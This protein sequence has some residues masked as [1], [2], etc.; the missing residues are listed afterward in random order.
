MR[1]RLLP[2][3]ETQGLFFSIISQLLLVLCF[4]REILAWNILIGMFLFA[5]GQQ[6]VSFARVPLF[7]ETQSSKQRKPMKWKNRRHT[8]HYLLYRRL[9]QRKHRTL[10]ALI[11]S[12]RVPFIERH[13][14]R[15]KFDRAFYAEEVL[16]DQE[17]E[18]S[19]S[20]TDYLTGVDLDQFCRTMDPIRQYRL[21]KEFQASFVLNT[22][23]NSGDLR[24]CSGRKKWKLLMNDADQWVRFTTLIASA[25]G[26]QVRMDCDST[27][28]EL[29]CLELA[30]FTRKRSVYFSNRLNDLPIVIDSGATFS[31]T[32]NRSDFIGELRAAPVSELNGLSSTTAVEGVGTVEWTIRDLFGVTR[33]IRTQAC[34]VPKASIRLFSPQAY[35]QDQNAGQYLMTPKRSVLTLADGSELEFPYNPGSNLPLMLPSVNQAVAGLTF[36]DS[37]YLTRPTLLSSFLS[38][39]DETNQNLTASQKELLV[40]HWKLGH[41]GFQWVQHLAST[42]R[43]P[44]DGIDYPILH[45]KHPRVS[46]CPAPLCTACQLAKQNRRGAGTS[47]EI[48]KS[49]KLHLLRRDEDLL[50]GRKVSIDQYISSVPGRLPNTKGKELKKDR[51][52]GGTLFVDHSSAYV[53]LQ[54][55]VSLRVGETLRAKHSFEK[56]AASHGVK[57]SGFRADNV[58]FA[59]SEFVADLESK[60]QA[61]DY[62]GTGAHHQNGVAERAIQTI[63]RW[64]RAMLLHS[65]IHWPEQADLSLWPFAMEYAVYLWNV[66]PSVGSRISPLELFS[67][68]KFPPDYA[69]LQRAHVWGCP[70]YVLD[71][72]LQDGKKLPKWTPRSRRGQFLGVSPDHSTTIGRILNLRTGHV[73]PQF[74]VV[75]DDLYST[76]PNAETGGLLD[77]DR[78]QAE[79]WSRLIAAGSERYIEDEYDDRGNVLPPPPLHDDWL[80]PAERRLREEARRERRVRSQ[81]PADPGPRLA[82]EGESESEIDAATPDP[83]VVPLAEAQTPLPPEGDTQDNEE[84]NN[85]DNNPEP[86]GQTATRSGR[87]IKLNNKFFGEQWANY[88]CGKDPRQKIRAGCLNDQFLATL[89][90]K[91]CLSTFRSHDANAMMAILKQ[92]TDDRH[93]TIEWMHPLA[94]SSLANAADHP[95]WEQAMNGPDKAGYWEACELELKTLTEKQDAWDVID[96]KPW[97][98]VLPTTWA[99]RCKRFPD[100]SIRKLKSRFCVRGDKQIEGV[101]Y[102]DTFAPVVSWTTVRLMLILSIILGLATKQVDYTAAFVQAPID[103][104]PQWENLTREERERRGVF[105]EMPRGFKEPGKVLRLK[106]SLYG[107]KQS[108]RNFFSH[109]KEKLE[110]VGFESIHDVDPC[111]FVSDKVICLVY[112]DDT[113]FFSPKQE[114][115]DDVIRRLQHEHN[116]D[117]EVEQDV[118][119]FLGIHLD[120]DPTSGHIKLTQIGLIKRIIAMLGVQNDSVKSTPAK[121]EPLVMDRDGD[122][123]NA[124]YN[125]ASVV[126]MLQYLQAHSRPDITYAVSQCARYVHCPK[127]SHELALEHIGRYLKGTLEQ[128]LILN[129]S[130]TLDLDCYVDAD[131][132]GLWPYEDKQDPSCVKSRTGFAICIS[133]CPVIWQS[134]LQEMIALSTMEAE[135]VALSTSLREVL[136]I[137]RLVR[138]VGNTVGFHEDRLTTFKTTVWEDNAGTLTLANLEPGRMTPRSKHYAI[139]YHWFRSHLKPNKI[140]IEKID[141]AHQRADILTKGLVHSKF[142]DVRKLLCGW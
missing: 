72:Q 58:P 79:S 15:S 138:A 45:T 135:Y 57:I 1:N 27:E 31:L 113:L 104:D 137:Q 92:H 107:L 120:R 133:N 70:V 46:S 128:G 141:S 111:L 122:P 62:S 63:T 85:P 2:G 125:Y 59:A 5:F 103:K 78:F 26:S 116:L 96:R 4:G 60:G 43:E 74:H 115:I 81:L 38:V 130:D 99:F 97:M 88:Q 56:F 25:K 106:R 44:L 51:Y 20:D 36:E 114:F 23:T 48:P 22:T 30:D 140:V 53:H 129:P 50:P 47:I 109:L 98:N 87:Q 13:P 11:Q 6:Y 77:L 49:D 134:K 35:F 80:T 19:S 132:A 86:P 66:M 90:W 95:T 131:F 139:R 73:S 28:F 32:P 37:Q 69:H 82:P 33:T 124:T 10:R 126:G 55:Q 68:T 118:A 64:S 84:N 8:R 3:R 94:L 34:Y 9:L 18:V 112:V 127:R 100:G 16:W 71:P 110:L 102:F 21:L 52:N 76:V 123:P 75:Y 17:E 108:P 39:A 83:G 89:D 12:R 105:I 42:P 54:H 24:Q 41:A 93:D 65:I 67:S 7:I 61:I 121:R 40:W 14:R 101:D 117:L 136:P 119:G 91:Q 142:L 29:T